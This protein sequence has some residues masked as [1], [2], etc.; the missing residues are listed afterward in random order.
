MK[1]AARQTHKTLNIILNRIGNSQSV[2]FGWNSYIHRRQN[3]L[4]YY[5]MRDAR[6]FQ[7]DAFWNTV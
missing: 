6:G 7:N 1:R 2:I 3:L 4:Y 5:L